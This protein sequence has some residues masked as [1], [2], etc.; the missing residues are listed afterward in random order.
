MDQKQWDK[1]MT[2]YQ[3]G[4][5]QP[6][7]LLRMGQVMVFQGNP[8]RAESLY[9]ALITQDSMSTN[10]KFAMNELGKLHFRQK[11]YAGAVAI[12]KR[13]IALDPNNDEAYYYLGLSYKELKQY[14]DAIGSLRRAAALAD[15]KADRHFWLGLLLAQVDSSAAA[16][17][18]LKRVV[19]LD[20]AGT[21]KNTGV[22]LRQLGFYRLLAKD[23][24]TAISLLERAVAINDKD[25]QA[26]VWL[27]Q[28]YQNS[29]NRPKAC[30]TYDR[31]LALKPDQAD[32]IKGKKSLGC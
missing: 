12:F 25:D 31:V 29:G 21:N 23:N 9:N 15:T 32:A 6:E 2:D 18:E 24:S 7:D 13:R 28:G 22:A 1:A 19:E 11:D 10:G 20:S 26:L 27:A 30:E 3:K 14:P 5:P 17:I 8:A 16:T 4:D